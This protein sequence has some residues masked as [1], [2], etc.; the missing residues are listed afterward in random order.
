[1]LD[2][3]GGK[4]WKKGYDLLGPAGMLVAFGFANMSN[5]EKRKLLHVASNFLSTPRFSPLS[6]M[7]HNRAV[8][9]VNIGHLWNRVDMLTGEIDA[10][11]ALYRDNKIK[12][13]IDHVFKFADVVEA[14]RRMHQRKNIGKIVLVP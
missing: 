10:L 13:T 5:G 12:P 1:V 2:P 6:L 14:H 4:D 3:L 11:L 9:G 7:D 8:A